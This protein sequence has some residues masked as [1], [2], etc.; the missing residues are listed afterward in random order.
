M[1]G[2]TWV[3]NT[4]INDTPPRGTCKG[5][6]PSI[7]NRAID[8]TAF[9]MQLKYLRFLARNGIYRLDR[10]LKTVIIMTE[11]FVQ[12]FYATIL[13]VDVINY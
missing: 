7:I 9:L 8:V 5:Y 12:Q 4:V 11:A 3:T 2:G 6:I 1:V 10:S 13:N